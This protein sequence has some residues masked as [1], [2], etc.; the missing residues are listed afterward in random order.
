MKLSERQ[1]IFAQ[2]VAKLLQYIASK[3]FLVTFGEAF[4]TQEQA[5]IYAQAGKGIADSLHCKRLA[6][7]LNLINDEGIYLP[8]SADYKQFGTYWESLNVL[9]EWGGN[10]KRSDGN[11]FQMDN[12]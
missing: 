11:H 5:N 10:W 6:V 9:N 1:A 4:R 2:N 7:D 8:D 12:I 3:G